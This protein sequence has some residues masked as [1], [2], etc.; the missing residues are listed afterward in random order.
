[1]YC[2]RFV[3]VLVTG[4]IVYYCHPPKLLQL[5]T[6]CP[7]SIFLLWYILRL[8]QNMFDTFCWWIKWPW[9]YTKYLNIFCKDIYCYSIILQLDILLPSF[10]RLI[11]I[12]AFN[13]LTAEIVWWWE[14]KI[15]VSL[16][17]MLKMDLFE[18]CQQGRHLFWIFCLI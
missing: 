3:I 16:L 12:V 6:T 4:T 11:I 10:I 5:S 15:V 14:E 17:M 18:I 9:H 13:L 2:D 1:M 8:L 7:I